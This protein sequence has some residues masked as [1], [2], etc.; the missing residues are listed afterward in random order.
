MV[1]ALAVA[2]RSIGGGGDF[3]VSVSRSSGSKLPR[4]GFL[5]PQIL[6]CHRFGIWGR[7]AAQR[8]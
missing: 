2:T 3:F 6:P 5:R 1:Y 4:H 8:G 7:F